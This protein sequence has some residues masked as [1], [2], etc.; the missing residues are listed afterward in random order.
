MAE[1]SLYV[2]SRTELRESVNVVSRVTSSGGALMSRTLSIE[3]ILETVI[4]EFITQ[5][6]RNELI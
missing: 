3:L 6:H 1:R 2:I 5:T 4:P